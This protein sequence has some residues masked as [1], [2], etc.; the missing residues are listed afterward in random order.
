MLNYKIK[1]SEADQLFSSDT[2]VFSTNKTDCHDLTKILL[3]VTL[4]T[5]DQQP[6]TDCHDLIKIMLIVTLMTHNQQPKTD[7][8]D[9]TKIML[10]VTLMTRKVK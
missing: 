7:C 4:M 9:L 5:R 2:L 1:F 3:I 6:K 8:H 10:I